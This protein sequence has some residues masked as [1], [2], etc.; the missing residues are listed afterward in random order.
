MSVIASAKVVEGTSRA[1]RVAVVEDDQALREGIIVP[2]LAQFGFDA[3]GMERASDL[4]RHM[5]ATSFDM[6]VLDLGLPGEDGVSTAR[7]LRECSTIG[8]VV[9]TGSHESED[10]VRAMLAGADL[11]LRKPSGLAVLAASLHSLGRRLVSRTA[12]H[13]ARGE[14]ETRMTAHAIDAEW[15]LAVNDWSL[16][17]PK[18]AA[19]PLSPSERG[20]LRQLFDAQGATVSREALIAALHD[21]IHEFDPHRLEMLIYRLRRKAKEHG[22]DVLPLVTV[23]GAGYAFVKGTTRGGAPKG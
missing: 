16:I 10:Q 6:V 12:P 1:W 7:Y 4:Y 2:G 14:P 21:D 20:V 17:P 5:V 9:L 19:V 22:I 11:Y 23:R 15:R 3:I 8:I 13:D 18:G